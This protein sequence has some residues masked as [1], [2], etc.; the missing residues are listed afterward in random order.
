MKIFRNDYI[1]TESDLLL[2]IYDKEKELTDSSFVSFEIYNFSTDVEAISKTLATKKDT[3]I[4]YACFDITTLANADY[5]IKWIYEENSG[6]TTKK[7][8]FKVVSIDDYIKLTAKKEYEFDF[9]TLSYFDEYFQDFHI[10]KKRYEK[11]S[12]EDKIVHIKEAEK[13]MINLDFLFEYDYNDYVATTNN[14]NLYLDNKRQFLLNA[15]DSDE[16]FEEK[17]KKAICECS[18]NIFLNR[19]KIQKSLE[20]KEHGI[21]S[22]NTNKISETL[23]HIDNAKIWLGNSAYMLLIDYLRTENRIIN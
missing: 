17:F 21:S 11:M 10:D 13:L 2:Y 14:N 9:I 19:F 12:K 18:L 22:Y 7:D 20:L 16:F 3:G 23:E 6:L 5:Y 8:Y 15:M 4:Y 1:L